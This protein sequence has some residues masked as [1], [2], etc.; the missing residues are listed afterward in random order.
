MS[1]ALLAR[2]HSD[3]MDV[4]L[5]EVIPELMG[6]AGEW[7]VD[8]FRLKIVN[9]MTLEL[10]GPAGEWLIDVF[11]LKIVNNMTLELMGPAGEWLVDAFD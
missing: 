9:N 3:W 1:L 2:S 5:H 6:P 8:V 10:M 11:R 7:L 4:G